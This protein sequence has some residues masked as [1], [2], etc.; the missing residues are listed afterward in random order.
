MNSLDYSTP[1]AQVTPSRTEVAQVRRPVSDWTRIKLNSVFAA[2]RAGAGQGRGDAYKPWLAIRRNFSSPVSHQIAESVGINAR[3]HHL[4]SKLEFRTALLVAYLGVSEEFREGLPMWP[5]EHPHPGERPGSTRVQP[6]MVPG[7]LDIARDAGVEHGY[8][9]GS[10]VPYIGTL[11]HMHTL[12]PIG[13][14]GCL[15]GIS[16]KPLSRM[17]QS[18]RSQERLEL[19]RRYCVAIGAH[20]VIEHGQDF[21]EPFFKTL[22]KQLRDYKPLTSEIRRHRGTQQLKDF[23]GRFELL[24]QG[25]SLGD[26]IREAGGQIGLAAEQSYL[27][28]RLSAWMHLVDVDLTQPLQMGRPIRRGSARVLDVLRQRYLGNRH[29]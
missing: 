25:R 7:L 28:F 10:K 17:L 12:S 21:N 23:A 6:T 18:L 4:F 16:C 19:D 27:F 20:H 13:A 3:N 26:A 9:V 2:V 29:E 11:D 24:A 15:L 14:W 8:F 22:L 1:H 5:F